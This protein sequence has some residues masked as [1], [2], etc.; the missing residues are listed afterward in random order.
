ME[1]ITGKNATI[2]KILTLGYN[3]YRK[4]NTV[5]LHIE[6]AVIALL[7]C[8]TKQLGGHSEF[9]PD[10]HYMR[11]HY[12]SCH[13]R[14]CPQCSNLQIERWLKK[15]ESRLIACDHFHMIFT[16]SH[17]FNRIWQ[18]N[19]K[20]MANI[21]FLSAKDTVFKLLVTGKYLGAKVGIIG[22]LH[23]WTKTQL[24]HP[25]L[26]FLITGGGITKEGNWKSSTN[27]FLIPVKLAM[28]IFRTIF[29]WRV[30][31]AVRSGKLI[32][33][34]GMQYKDLVKILKKTG[35][36]KWNVRIEK[37]Y[38]HGK[39]I[40]KYIVRYMKGGSIS[41]SRILEVT[42][43]KVIISYRDNKDKEDSG[44]GKK[45]EMTLKIEEFIRR[46]LLHIPWHRARYVRYYGIY[47]SA[48]KDELDKCRLILGQPPVEEPEFLD[49]ETY[50]SQMGNKILTDCPECGKKLILTSHVE[51]KAHYP[52]IEQFFKKAA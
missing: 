19:K 1:V 27:G 16:I 11:S 26:H 10:G 46:Y 49:W 47:S 52:P 37:K 12:N 33:P 45:K 8:R 51:P 48:K 20:E 30:R 25:H 28:K 32:L 40:L 18:R 2:Q 4:V 39:G 7:S 13:H 38:S 42:N 6:K 31:K 17:E 44:R 34:E 41:N 14:A 24:L 43:K 22:S 3:A 23:T 21:L 9:C 5:P 50:L 15:Q 36:I 35:K 29:R